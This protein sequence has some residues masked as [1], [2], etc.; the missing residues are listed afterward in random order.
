MEQVPLHQRRRKI[1]SSVY[2]QGTGW[3]LDSFMQKTE[4]LTKSVSNQK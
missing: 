1:A 3:K 2:A 4:Y